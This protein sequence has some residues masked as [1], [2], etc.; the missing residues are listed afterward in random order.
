MLSS[1]VITNLMGLLST[2]NV[3][4]LRNL[5]LVNFNLILHI[6][7]VATKLDS[8]CQH[9]MLYAWDIQPLGTF[10]QMYL[11]TSI[12]LIAQKEVPDI[13]INMIL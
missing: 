13:I 4:Q 3:V 10:L 1:T 11:F 7:L 12:S 8:E 9:L 5:V 6:W 2:W